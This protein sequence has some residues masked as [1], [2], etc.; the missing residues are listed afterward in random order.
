LLQREEFQLRK[1]GW[2]ALGQSRS[3]TR[4]VVEFFCE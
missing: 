2:I 3:D 1:N 4:E